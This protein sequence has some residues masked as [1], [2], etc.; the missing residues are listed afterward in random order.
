M[1]REQRRYE[2]PAVILLGSVHDVT[3]GVGSTCDD[4]AMGTGTLVG[5]TSV[6]A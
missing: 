3:L 4:A 6:C 2:A 1:E 5:T